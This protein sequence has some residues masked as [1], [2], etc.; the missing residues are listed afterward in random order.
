MGVADVGLVSKNGK[1]ED[2]SHRIRA[3]GPVAA[4]ARRTKLKADDA[5][6]E[7]SDGH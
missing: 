5:R 6:A 4:L 2:G 1:R 7:H 3:S